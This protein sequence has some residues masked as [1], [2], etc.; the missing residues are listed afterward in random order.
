[1]AQ[2]T[3]KNAVVALAAVALGWNAIAGL[4]RGKALML[5]SEVARAEDPVGFWAAVVISGALSFGA[6]LALMF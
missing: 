1:M 2:L 4:R 5:Y 3:A 6:M